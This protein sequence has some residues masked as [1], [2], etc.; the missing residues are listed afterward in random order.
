[1]IMVI[2]VNE[3]LNFLTLCCWCRFLLGLR[4]KRSK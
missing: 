3:G 2:V 4:R 1:M